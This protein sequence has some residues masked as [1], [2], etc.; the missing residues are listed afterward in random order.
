MYRLHCYLIGNVG[1]ESTSIVRAT[2]EDD[3]SIIATVRTKDDIYVIEPSWR[4]APESDNHTMIIY[5]KSDVKMD[6]DMG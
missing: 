1:E 6:N 4:H 2:W 3:S 5:R